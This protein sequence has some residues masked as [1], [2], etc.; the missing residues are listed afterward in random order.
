[1]ADPLSIAAS[2]AGLVSLGFQ[3]GGGITQYLDAL[4]CRDA[5]ISS[6]R[7]Q[8]KALSDTLSVIEASLV[9]LRTDH[10]AATAAAKAC[11]DSC[12]ASLMALQGLVAKVAGPGQATTSKIQGHGR[13]LLYPFK[14]PKLQ[15][16]EAKL[17][18]TNA[19]LQLALQALGL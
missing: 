3:V 16:L 8:N 12:R 10:H 5:D 18:S 7:Q 6:A 2:A 1:M 9:Q 4:N 17:G 14:R 13:K 11:L 15:Q 19:A